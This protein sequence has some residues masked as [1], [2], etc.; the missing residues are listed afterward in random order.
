MYAPQWHPILNITCDYKLLS[1]K[2]KNEQREI[3]K[4]NLTILGHC[5]SHLCE[6][7]T[8]KVS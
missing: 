5:T 4:D 6:L 2:C 8:Y 1:S 3:T 7:S